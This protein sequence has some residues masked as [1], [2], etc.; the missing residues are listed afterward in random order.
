MATGPNIQLETL[1][2]NQSCQFA[3]RILASLKE[4]QALWED[5]TPR[6]HLVSMSCWYMQAAISLCRFA[7]E[8]DALTLMSA[9]SF[10]QEKGLIFAEGG[11]TLHLAQYFVFSMIGT[12][13]SLYS[14]VTPDQSHS[15]CWEKFTIVTKCRVTGHSFWC[16]LTSDLHRPRAQGV[17]WSLS[18]FLAGFGEIILTIDR[19]GRTRVDEFFRLDPGQLNLHILQKTLGFKVVWT[20]ILGSHLDVDIST[21][22][23]FLFRQATL[24]IREAADNADDTTLIRSCLDEEIMG[25]DELRELMREILLSLHIL[26]GQTAHSRGHFNEDEAFKNVSQTWRDSML[27][28]VCCEPWAFEGFDQQP[29]RIYN[30]QSD[31]PLLGSKLR[32]LA[33]EIQSQEPKSLRQLWKDKRNTLQWWTFWA[34]IMFGGVAT[35]L[36]LIQTILA[37]L[38]LRDAVSKE[39]E[40]R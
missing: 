2:R 20:D 9:T 23:L 19:E 37:G 35:L 24:C 32:F 16:Y 17:E 40:P 25:R 14:V 4:S 38:Q 11:R 8:Y 22:T 12:L 6:P 30:L 27:K 1:R 31:F 5:I 36:S 13:S 33:L 29:K 3:F 15:C 39:R 7:S 21:S 18:R 26:Y 28:K 34:V 10:L